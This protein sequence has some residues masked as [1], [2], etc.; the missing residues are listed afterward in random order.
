MTNLFGKTHNIYLCC[1]MFVVFFT[2]LLY[3]YQSQDNASVNELSS[4]RWADGFPP[5]PGFKQG[6]CW[7]GRDRYCLCS[8]S[9]AID[10]IIEYQDQLSNVINVVLVYRREPPR[11]MYAIP[12][13]FVNV[14]ETVEQ[15]TIREVKEETNL[16]ITALE[17]F[18]MYSDPNRDPRRHTASMV[19]R[20]R[21]D[22][23][24]TLKSG[25]DAKQVKLFPLTEAVSLPLA[26]DHRKILTDYMH[27][28]HSSLLEKSI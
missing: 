28:Y 17:Q 27:R 8:P 11:S 23:I 20:C 22:D 5:K 2:G 19:F 24:S 21:V 14:G 18:A 15:A 25:D 12:G 13:G 4:Y 7:C 1:A 6:S 10:G 9:L 16:T 26:F 3:F